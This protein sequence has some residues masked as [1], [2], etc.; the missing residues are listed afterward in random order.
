MFVEQYIYLTFKMYG[1]LNPKRFSI[2]FKLNK[3]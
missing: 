2:P 1:I 3:R